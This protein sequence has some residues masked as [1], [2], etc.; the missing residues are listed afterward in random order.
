MWEIASSH[1]ECKAV[2]NLW[3]RSEQNLQFRQLF[4]INKG[5]AFTCT[6]PSVIMYVNGGP[7]KEGAPF[8]PPSPPPPPTQRKETLVATVNEC[9]RWREGEGEWE[10]ESNI[11]SNICPDF[12]RW[13]LTSIHH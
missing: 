13:D 7:L 10:R 5:K 12:G 8:H 11:I 9:Q 4:D 3:V 6:M 1:M 2:D